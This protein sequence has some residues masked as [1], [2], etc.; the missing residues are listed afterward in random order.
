[1]EQVREL[2]AAAII[3]AGRRLYAAGMVAGNSGNISVNLAGQGVLMTPTGLCKGDL[4][5]D[6][7]VLLNLAGEQL[8]GN[9]RATSEAGMHLAVYR[10]RSELGAVVHCHSPYATAFA[11]RGLNLAGCK[12]AEVTERLGDIPLLPYAKPGSRELA[13]QVGEAAA[14]GYSGALLADHGVVVWG[15]DLRDAMYGAEELEA[16]CKVLAIARQ[17]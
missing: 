4:G 12:L 9:L 10:A 11:V 7:L 15:R 13:E 17:L 14:A 3:E 5:R 2:A 6:S 16:V 1:M 8:S